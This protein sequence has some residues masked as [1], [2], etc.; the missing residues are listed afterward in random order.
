MQAI[1]YTGMRDLEPFLAK[2]GTWFI[3]LGLFM[4]AASVIMW[5]VLMQ[6]IY[7]IA[8][9]GNEVTRPSTWT[10]VI[11]V[12][13]FSENKTESIVMFY[14]AGLAWLFLGPLLTTFLG[15][16]SVA[17]GRTFNRTGRKD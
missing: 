10:E 4:L 9:N 14:R 3:L 8:F 11:S 2:R 5:I 13:A 17:L 6:A 15:L 16:F 1:D 12:I 7:L